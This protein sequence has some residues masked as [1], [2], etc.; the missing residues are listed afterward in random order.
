M[1]AVTGLLSIRNLTVDY[2]GEGG[3]VRA[4]DG[5]DLDL[6]AGET[7]A[8]VGESGSGKSTVAMAPLGLLPPGARIAGSIRLAGAELLGLP[9]PALRPVRGGRIGMVFQ[10]PA[11]SLNPVLTVGEQIREALAAHAVC[12]GRAARARAV[13]LLAE[14]GIADPAARAGQYPHE[15][16]GGMR[17]RAM[18]AMALA[19]SP[20]LLIADEPTTALDVTVQAQILDLFRRLR[21]RRGMALLLVTHDL[22]VVAELADRV[23]VMKEGRVVE[24]GPVRRVLDAPE[25]GYTRELLAATLSVD[26]APRWVGEG[27]PHQP[28][29]PESPLPLREGGR[30]GGPSVGAGPGRSMTAA[31][32]NPLSLPASPRQPCP[33][34]LPPSREG[35]GGVS[36]T[37]AGAALP[38]T[39]AGSGLS[40]GISPSGTKPSLPLPQGE[41]ESGRQGRRS[42]R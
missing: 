36:M 3:A 17:Q 6:A 16:S 41:G 25:H 38:G 30:G 20:G 35:R 19:A 15:L 2:L 29:P 37:G 40:F 28:K 31:S 33:F 13:E 24:T 1:T 9:E 11:T 12:R 32:T 21:D 27:R 39:S 7:L 34:I 10:E 8:L 18:I 14:V 23:A 5:V 4:V 26:D 22:G 42:G